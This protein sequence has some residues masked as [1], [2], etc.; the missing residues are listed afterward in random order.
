MRRIPQTGNGYRRVLAAMAVLVVVMGSS[1]CGRER[2]RFL[3]HDRG[4]INLDRVTHVIPQI[5]I[6]I[7]EF[8]LDREHIAKVIGL[9]REGKYAYFH[10]EA[11]IR[12]DDFTWTVFKSDSFDKVKRPVTDTDLAAIRKALSRALD[13]YE[14]IR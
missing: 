11:L 6:G 7:D 14:E 9:I 4:K 12:F 13:V 3:E 8:P 1:G 10:V 5:R 2:P